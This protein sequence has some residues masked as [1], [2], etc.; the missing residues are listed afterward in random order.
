MRNHIRVIASAP[1]LKFGNCRPYL[2]NYER[3]G[4]KINYKS[5]ARP[6]VS[7]NI[8]NKHT[9]KNNIHKLTYKSNFIRRPKM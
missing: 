4:N 1:V 6:R 7:M 3:R 5:L 8:Y 2:E 9:Y